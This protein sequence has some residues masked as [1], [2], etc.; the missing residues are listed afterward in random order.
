MPVEPW[1]KIESIAELDSLELTEVHLSQFC[2]VGDEA[3]LLSTIGAEPTSTA[4]LV[5]DPQ[6]LKVISTYSAHKEVLTALESNAIHQQI[7]RHQDECD[8]Y[9]DQ[10]GRSRYTTNPQQ[11]KA[12]L[13][14][15]M[16]KRNTDQAGYMWWIIEPDNLLSYARC[17]PELVYTRDMVKVSIIKSRYCRSNY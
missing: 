2:V 8:G 16:K 9:C 3:N 14:E 12:M 17:A 4:K 11:G 13:I 15:I 1:K 5:S 7:Q 6:K 10:E